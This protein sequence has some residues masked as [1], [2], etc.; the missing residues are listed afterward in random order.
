[1]R[2]QQYVVG[3]TIA[4]LCTR[5]AQ[6]QDIE[7]FD[8]DGDGDIDGDDAAILRAAEQV[9]IIDKSDAQRLRESARAVTVIDTRQARERTADLGEVLSRA[10]GIQVRRSGGLGSA[11]RFSLNGLYDDQIRFF[12]DGIPLDFAGWGLGIANVP[13][14]LVQ[15]IEVH[16]G[17]V[18]IALG[19]DALGGAVNLVTDPS[20]VNRAS[21]SYQTGSFGTHRA[22]ASARARDATG[23]SLGLALFF[24]RARN[25]YPIDVRLTDARGK[26]YTARVAR[27]HDAYTAA[28]GS[29]ETGLVN[30]GPIKRALVRLFST[31]YDKELQHNIWGTLPYGD[32]TYGELTRGATLDSEIES[33]PWKGRMLVGAARRWIDFH[34]TGEYIYD[35][36]GARIRDRPVHGENGPRPVDQ[37]LRETGMFAR[38]LGERSLGHRQRLRVTL[39]PTAARRT[40]SD[41]LDSNPAGRDP[42]QAK[43]D[44][45]QVV[46]GI[47]HELTAM[48]ERLQNIGFV[49]GYSMW[50]DAEDA[51]SDYIFVPISQSTHRA[52]VGD[53]ARYRLTERLALK[54][55][56][57]WATRLPSV[58]EIF[59]DGILV[60]PNLELAPERSHNVNVG[61]RYEIETSRGAITAETNAFARLVDDLIAQ[62]GTDRLLSNQNVASARVLGLEGSAGY[63]VAGDWAS[64]D[65]SITF[66]DIRNAST[67]GPYKAFHGD[68]MPN[69]PWLLGSLG[70]TL[71]KRQLARGDD[72]LSLFANSRYVREFF[73]GWESAG[74]RDTKAV[75]ESQLVHNLGISYAVRNSTPVVT[76]IELQNVSDARVFDSYGVERPG[77]ALYV[78]LSTEL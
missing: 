8:A 20:W 39:A 2:C 43:R 22:T 6:A 66:Q 35:W 38:L 57:E 48:D 40:G 71:R 26:E 23:L 68:R 21:A 59:G 44:L 15:H 74:I 54:A 41:F 56:Y 16:R 69:R 7:P 10:Q 58:D 70:G 36:T 30:T 60:Q 61:A 28:G 51:R 11:A 53:A 78:K 64:I 5:G 63:V 76:T 55:S 14:E 67:T 77:R 46:F 3:A 31:D 73:L 37:R 19:A 13:V 25:D 45:T 65:G 34:D 47:E 50:T 32:A 17:V 33:G 18:P 27:F 24:D 9:E 62:L 75:V 29:I 72:E 4:C 49:K 1:V 12:L 52:G 42:I